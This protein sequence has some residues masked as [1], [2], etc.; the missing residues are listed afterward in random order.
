MSKSIFSF[1]PKWLL[2]LCTI[3]PNLIRNINKV[4]TQH[5]TLPFFFSTS[6]PFSYFLQFSSYP[7]SYPS[8]SPC[9]DLTSLPLPVYPSLTLR[10]PT[11]PPLTPISPLSQRTRSAAPLR[12]PPQTVLWRTLRPATLLVRRPRTGANITTAQRTG[13]VSAPA[14]GQPWARCALVRQLQALGR[15]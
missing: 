5:R 14:S 10:P 11:I 8:I 13:C 7:S 3:L 15:R 4:I 1:H 2:L 9:P 6:P 12:R